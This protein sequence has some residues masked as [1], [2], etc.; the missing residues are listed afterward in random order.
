MIQDDASIDVRVGGKTVRMNL[1]VFSQAKSGPREEDNEDM[2]AYNDSSF[3]L[4]D[5][6]TPKQGNAKEIGGLS[7]GRIA[8]E[9]VAQKAL[10]T[11]SNGRQLVDYLTDAIRT[12][13]AKS[14]PEALTEPRATFATTLVVARIVVAKGDLQLI[15]TQVGDT[16]FRING[17]DV[18]TEER[19]MDAIDAATR[20]A[21]IKRLIKQGTPEEK[22]VPLGRQSIEA[23]LNTQYRLWN[24]PD[25]PLGFGYINGYQVPDKFIR[26]HTFPLQSIH[27]LEVFSDGYPLLPTE[28]TVAA[29]ESA[30]HSV[31]ES[32]PYRYKKFP[33]T[34]PKDDRTIAVVR[35]L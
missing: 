24:N 34:K 31:Q 15:I 25:D 21:E 29:W 33:A 11:G 26:V 19:Q 6:S 32:D 18:Y 1:S 3:V 8:A 16:A 5:G 30:Y 4:A 23:S 20:A 13:Y 12:F 7:G 27:A 35:F 9:L 10:A 14:V 17:K 22:A 28:T 2:F